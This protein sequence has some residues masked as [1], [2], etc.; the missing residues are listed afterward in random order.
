MEGAGGNGKKVDAAE[1]MRDDE[2][3]RASPKV[4]QNQQNGAAL[5]EETAAASATIDRIRSSTVKKEPLSDVEAIDVRGLSFTETPEQKTTTSHEPK[6]EITATVSRKRRSTEEKLSTNGNV[7]KKP[8][9]EQREQFLSSLV[10]CD[11]VTA[12]ELGAR[13]DQLRADLQVSLNLTE[14]EIIFHCL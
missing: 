5:P 11:K 6:S 12:E 4:P 14:Y 1:R 2:S 3:S 13:A 9:F 8:R 10:G 7:L